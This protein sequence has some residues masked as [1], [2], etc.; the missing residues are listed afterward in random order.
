MLA[1]E[2]EDV[3][4][5]LRIPE[6]RRFIRRILGFCGLY[7]SGSTQN[8]KVYALSARRDVALWVLDRIQRTGISPEQFG[9]I[10]FGN[11]GEYRD[12]DFMEGMEDV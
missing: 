3:Q 9:A 4:S 10:Q 1:L 2:L 6:G 5:L 11:D 8:A 7:R 12:L